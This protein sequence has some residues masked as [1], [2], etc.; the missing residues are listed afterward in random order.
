MDIKEK[1][2]RSLTRSRCRK[3]PR[4]TTSSMDAA[5]HHVH[6]QK[7]Y[8]SSETLQS[9]E[10]DA[11]LHYGPETVEYAEQ[12]YAVGPLGVP[13]GGVKWPEQFSRNIGSV[14]AGGL[15][16]RGLEGPHVLTG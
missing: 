7:C 4:Y 13:A 10:Q 16:L 2:Q 6:P 15:G 1:R 8:G 14:I 5:E 11:R 3:E 12:V 9:Y